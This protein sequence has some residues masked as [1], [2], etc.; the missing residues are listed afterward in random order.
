MSRPANPVKPPYLDLRQSLDIVHAIYERG[1]GLLN[2]DDLASIMGTTV[3]SSAFRMK[4]LALKLFGLAQVVD[5]HTI[6]L[7]PIASA[8]VAPSSDG[9][10][11]EAKFEAFSAIYV[12]KSVYERYKGGYLPEDA[13]LGN[14]L[15]REFQVD[16]ES[17]NDWVECFKQSGRA[18]GILLDEGGKIRVLQS[19]RGLASVLNDAPQTVPT[20]A[21]VKAPPPQPLAELLIDENAAFTIPLDPHRKAVIPFHFDREDLEYLQGILELYVKR[22]EGKKRE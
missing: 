10:R 8:I 17:K 20:P 5:G 13:F 2:H 11:L 19:P 4:V 21:P 3:K 6:K 9:E 1:G 14:T 15:V 7:T 18:A 16:Q 22:R 12:L